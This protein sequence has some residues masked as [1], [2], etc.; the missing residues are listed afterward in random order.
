MAILAEDGNRSAFTIA[1]VAG[2]C[3]RRRRS[4]TTS[5]DRLL[6]PGA[7]DQAAEQVFSRPRVDYDEGPQVPYGASMKFIEMSGKTLLNLV[8]E[9]E[10]HA[11]RDA[12]ITGSIPWLTSTRK[13]TSKFGITPSGA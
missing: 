13:V 12:G 9:E 10:M 1:I 4:A 5:G 8:N 2:H 7:A 6:R 11:L 3:R